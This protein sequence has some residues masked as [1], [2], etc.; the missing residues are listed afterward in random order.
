MLI[1]LSLLTACE[2]KGIDC[3]LEAIYAV[4]IELNDQD[5]APIEDA[6]ISYTVD[7]VEGDGEEA[8]VATGS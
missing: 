2:E 3:T 8:V 6:V 4:N 1:L 5:S 7:G